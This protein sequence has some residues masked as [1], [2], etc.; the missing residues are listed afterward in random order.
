MKFQFLLVPA[1]IVATAT[2]PAQARVYMDVA[3]AQQMLFPG[4]TFEVK[5]VTLDQFQF[6]AIIKDSNV[7]IYSRNVK[8]WKAS[9]GGWFVLDQV[10][11]KD[12]WISYAI[13]ISPEGKVKQVEILECLE[14]Y[15]G[16]TQPNWRAQ[17]YGKQHGST[18]DDIGMISGATLSSG[19]MLSGVK[20]ILSTYALVLNENG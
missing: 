11:G 4:A 7:N 2:A 20:R 18:F 16:I 14:N 8:A 3:A 6:N 19:Q 5:H 1:A 10:R 13:A 9:T 15:D 17:F 12:D